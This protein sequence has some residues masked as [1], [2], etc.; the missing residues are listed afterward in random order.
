MINIKSYEIQP[1]TSIKQ[2]YIKCLVC[3]LVSYHPQDI[4]HKFCARCNRFHEDNQPIL[5]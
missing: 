2:A 1:A 4:E 5:K 3:G